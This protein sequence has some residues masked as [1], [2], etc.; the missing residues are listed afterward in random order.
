MSNLKAAGAG[1]PSSR[2]IV[3]VHDEVTAS[4]VIFLMSFSQ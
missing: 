4:T 1:L 3:A 2:R